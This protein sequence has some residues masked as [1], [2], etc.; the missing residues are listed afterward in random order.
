[1]NAARASTAALSGAARL[2]SSQLEL[3]CP[4]VLKALRTAEKAT[5]RLILR[6]ESFYQYL[7]SDE[8]LFSFAS[9]IPYVNYLALK[10]GNFRVRKFHK[11]EPDY[12]MS[13]ALAPFAAPVL[14]DMLSLEW[15]SELTFRFFSMYHL[16]DNE[17]QSA[18]QFGFDLWSPQIHKLMSDQFKNI[19][20]S[21]FNSPTKPMLDPFSGKVLS[22][23]KDVLNCIKK[24]FVVGPSGYMESINKLEN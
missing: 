18:P 23:V 22:S 21:D 1:M 16:I 15:A 2:R 11:E 19:D 17:N 14:M 5:D 4:E 8:P 6:S 24:E 12:F 20:H 13:D 3:Q 10:V 9:A 7:Q